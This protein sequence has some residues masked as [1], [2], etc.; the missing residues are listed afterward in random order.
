[1]RIEHARELLIY[2]DRRIIDIAVASGFT[3]TSQFAAW[4]RRIFG[5]NPSEVRGRNG[6]AA[7]TTQHSRLRL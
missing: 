2:S 5:T 7:S 4:Y 6:L 1:L 3:S